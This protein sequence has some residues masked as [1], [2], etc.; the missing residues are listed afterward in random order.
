MNKDRIEKLIDWFDQQMADIPTPMGNS[1]LSELGERQATVIA[2][3]D[4]IEE[5]ESQIWE[6]QR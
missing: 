5:L 2:M 4:R 6:M 3:R 1:F